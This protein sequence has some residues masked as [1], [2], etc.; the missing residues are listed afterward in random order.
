MAAIWAAISAFAAKTLIPA[1]M[2]WILAHVK[3]WVQAWA[4]KR[5]IDNQ[6]DAEEDNFKKTGRP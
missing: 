2:G 4:K 6:V 3:M 1:V 5:A